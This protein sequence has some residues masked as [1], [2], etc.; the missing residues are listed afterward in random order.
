MTTT[1]A[2]TIVVL[3]DKGGVGKTTTAVHL[4]A[5]LNEKNG[6][7]VLLDGDKNRS[8]LRT[9]GEGGK[10]PFKVADV[11]D[12]PE[13]M[14]NQRF[15]VVDTMAQ[16]SD[17]DVA[18]L[19]EVAE[20]IILPTSPDA[21]ALD[22]T[23]LLSR[24]LQE[25]GAKRLRV[26]LTQVP[27]FNKDGEEARQYLREIHVPVFEHYIRYAQVFRKA[28]LEGALVN[29]VRGSWPASGLAWRDYVNVSKEVL[30]TLKV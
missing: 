18:A 22:P 19:V 17:D 2:I 13:A 11:D 7:A 8:V 4:T 16:P 27:T 23:I 25:L 9:W 5:V 20:L 24:K 14:E 29:K 21:L 15:A 12:A 1:S 30:E 28:P 10:L 26:L 3:G 6:P